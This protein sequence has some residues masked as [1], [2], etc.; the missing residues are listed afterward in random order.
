MKKRILYPSFYEKAGIQTVTVVPSPIPNIT[1]MN[2]IIFGC[3]FLREKIII[4]YIAKRYFHINPRIKKFFRCTLKQSTQSDF[5]KF[6]RR[7]TLVLKA[8]YC[9]L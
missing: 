5:R 3:F 8:I 7:F 4:F 6:T 1:F 9:D 2:L